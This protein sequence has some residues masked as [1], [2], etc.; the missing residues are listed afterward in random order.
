L[1]ALGGGRAEDPELGKNLRR[2]MRRLAHDFIAEAIRGARAEGSPQR[3]RKA[4]AEELV[5]LTDGVSAM[6][7]RR[8]ALLESRK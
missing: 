7:G 5:L 2:H 1:Q 4:D 3:G 6:V 8:S